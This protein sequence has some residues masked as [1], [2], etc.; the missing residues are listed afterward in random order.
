M[1][2][3]GIKQITYNR[4]TVTMAIRKLRKERINRIKQMNF[5]LQERTFQPLS[6][7]DKYLIEM[8]GYDIGKQD[9]NIPRVTRRSLRPQYI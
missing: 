1:I 5:Q 8:A 6:E 7:E 3:R 9:E 2:R 4:G